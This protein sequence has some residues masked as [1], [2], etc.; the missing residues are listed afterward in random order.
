VTGSKEMKRALPFLLLALAGA[1]LTWLTPLSFIPVP[2]PDDSAFYFVAKG[3]FSWPPRWLM[4]GQA[5][6]EPTYRIWNFNTMP[7]FP[8]LIGLG[9]LVG[10]DGSHGLKLWSI[11]PWAGSAALLGAVLRRRG[12][13]LALALLVTLAVILNP[14]LRWASVVVRPESLIGLCGLA[15]VLGLT[16]GFPHRFRDRRGFDPIAALLAIGAYLHFNAVHLVL[17]V[18]F[19]ILAM[20]ERPWR[21][22]ARVAGLT[23]LYLTPWLVTVAAHPKIFLYQM[24]VQFHRLTIGNAWLESPESAISSLFQELGSPEPWPHALKWAGALLWVLIAVALSWGLIVPLAQTLTEIFWRKFVKTP[25]PAL[26]GRNINLLPASGWVLAGAWLWHS[27]PEVWFT[28]YLHLALATFAGIALLQLTKRMSFQAAGSLTLGLVALCGI[29]GYADYTQAA[30]LYAQPTWRWSRYHE[31][32]DC[33]DQR[34]VRLERELGSPKPLRVWA[35]TFPDVTVELGRRHPDWALT[36]TNDFW[37]RRHLA[38]K[39]A[40][41]V[42]AVVI[43]ETLSWAE[44]E[45]T[46]PASEHPDVQSQWMNWKD[47]FYYELTKKP[48]WKPNRWICQRGRWQAFLFMRAVPAH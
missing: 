35:P 3:L 16:F 18:L 46:G 28:Y 41:E 31:L 21:K 12:L 20:H 36:R 34:L 5:P 48:D 27:K 37:E 40:E 47:Y 26:G 29:F 11:L 38:L 23:T 14:E 2:W 1:L 25:I 13:P 8:I 10:I 42:E 43:P 6:F 45:I 17:P 15:L 33:I 9:R 32:V 4:L 30:S 7:L 22:L 39:H 24:D 44:R 19:G